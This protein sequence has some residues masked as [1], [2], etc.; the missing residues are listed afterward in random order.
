MLSLAEGMIVPA[1]AVTPHAVD[2]YLERWRPAL[3]DRDR[4][5]HE[6]RWL[7]DHADADADAKE[8]QPYGVQVTYVARLGNR[9]LGVVVV[10]QEIRTVLPDLDA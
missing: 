4:A 6:I 3:T 2:R 9:R 10:D 1:L 5:E 8:I 7:L